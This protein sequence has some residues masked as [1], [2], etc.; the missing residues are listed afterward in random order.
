MPVCGGCFGCS[1]IGA[2]RLPCSGWRVPFRPT[3]PS[4]GPSSCRPRGRRTRPPL[5][6]LPGDRRRHRTGPRGRSRSDHHRDDRHGTVG[7][8]TGRDSPNTRRLVVDHGGFLYDSDSYADDLP[9]WVT[10]GRQGPFGHAVHV[11]HQ[12]HALRHAAG[13]HS[14]EQFFA[15]SAMR[16]TCSTPKGPR[17]RRCSPSDC[18]PASS[19][20]RPDSRLCNA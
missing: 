8:Y 12:R 15:Y 10:V 20:G 11:G 19:G 17:L 1:S 5:D 9:S 14:G 7:W 16:S 2:F 13:L 6:Q 4:P 3:H 18:M